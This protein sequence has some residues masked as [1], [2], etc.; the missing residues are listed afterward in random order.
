[1]S[2]LSV[3]KKIGSVA[4]GVEHVA[5]PLLE[6]ADPALAPA[7]VIADGWFTRTF[8]AVASAETLITAAKSGGL[9]QAAVVQ[10]FE[11]GFQATQDALAVASKTMQ[12]D[13]NQYKAVSDA[14]TAAYNA[15]AAF[16]ATWKIVDLPPA[17]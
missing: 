10:D 13:I 16:K 11:L 5:I 1:M 9:K 12:Y 15:A 7:L 3:L 4:L 6:A 8:K 17:Q 2:F 14:F